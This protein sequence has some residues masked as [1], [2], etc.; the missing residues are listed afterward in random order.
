MVYGAPWCPDCRRAK[1]FLSA[2]RV[3]YDWTD[4]D[5]DEQALARVQELQHGGRTI[6]T[7]VFADGDVLIEPSDS[8]LAAKLGI[9]VRAE[10]ACYDLI[11]V[12][13]GPAGLAAAMYAA[14]EGIDA[15]VIDSGGLGGN[16]G[17]TERIDNYPGFPRRD[18]RPGADGPVHR[19]GP[20]LRRRTR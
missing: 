8:E 4:I 18:R 14:R 13:G 10:R 9:A 2:H 20:P 11:I 5:Q 16:A 3:A 7:V 1:A 17:V 19:P 6:P 15:V 12:G